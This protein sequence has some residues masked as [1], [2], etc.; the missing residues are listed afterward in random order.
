MRNDV[1]ATARR[2]AWLLTAGI[3]A[4]LSLPRPA[5]AQE[6]DTIVTIAG[7]TGISLGQGDAWVMSKLS[8]VFLDIDV[9]LVFDGD[10]SLEWTPSLIM[11]LS[12]RVSVGVNP[13][14]KRVWW[15]DRL[16]VYGG[17]GFPFFF[18]PF[19]L[20]GVEPAVGATYRLI[21]RLSLALEIHADVF[22]AGS[23]LPDAAILAKMDVS[24]GV[25]FAF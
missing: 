11:E 16:S 3:I 2:G 23:D 4:A 5:A 8:P 14:L 24:V 19:T 7:G 15:F 9:G 10:T 6:L 12:G 25:R 1:R 21:P 13:S 18:A 17:I 22:F 20:I